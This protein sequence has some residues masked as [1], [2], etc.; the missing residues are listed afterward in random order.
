MDGYSLSDDGLCINLDYCEEKENKECLKCKDDVYNEYGWHLSFCI[1]KQ[2]GCVENYNENCL[3]CDDIHDMD[4]C[5]E[6]SEG[7]SS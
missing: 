1:N 7:W 6:C 5:S 4:Q 3:R 2:L